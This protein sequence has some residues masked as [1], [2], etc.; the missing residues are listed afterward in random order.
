MKLKFPEGLTHFYDALGTQFKP[1]AEGNVITDLPDTI[2]DMVKSGFKKLDE[3][4]ETFLD[5]VVDE[6]KRIE[7]LVVKFFHHDT[8]AEVHSITMPEEATP[9]KISA[10]GKEAVAEG[11]KVELNG[12][13]YQVVSVNDAGTEVR[14][15]PVVE[16]PAA[17]D[18]PVVVPPVLESGA[19]T[20][21]KVIDPDLTPPVVEPKAGTADQSANTP[22]A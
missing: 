8:G 13:M 18:P 17:A 11:A 3:N 15:T 12:K 22:P 2:R 6:F 5:K 21:E 9:E 7:G 19:A 14:V 20:E 10:L 16:T 4:S 1:D